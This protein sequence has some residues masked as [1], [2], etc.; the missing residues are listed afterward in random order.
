MVTSFLITFVVLVFPITCSNET[1]T[2]SVTNCDGGSR[3][4]TNLWRIGTEPP[5]F[6]FGTVHVPF[7]RVWDVISEDAKSAF[8]AADKAYFELGKLSFNPPL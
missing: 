1:T 2:T 7:N 6:F 8:Q 5:S 3:E 4:M